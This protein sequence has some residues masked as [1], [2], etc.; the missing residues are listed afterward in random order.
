MDTQKEFN[1]KLADILKFFKDE[2]SAI[3]G[4]RPTPALVEDIQV[5]YY[6]QHVPIKQV[7]SISIVPPREIQVM[8][9]DIAVVPAL[10][11][12]VADKLNVNPANDGTTIHI[13]LPSLTDERRTDL[14]KIIKTKA[15]EARIKSRA[16]RDDVKKD[17]IAQEKAGT[18]TEDDRFVIQESIQKE[19]DAFNKEVDALVEKKMGEI[20]E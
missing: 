17:S 20:N 18:I 5:E 2:A 4:S 7:G 19:L 6:G 13:N 8:V 14:I 1:Q 3:R 15:E 12:T 9:W 11:K 16:A 10:M